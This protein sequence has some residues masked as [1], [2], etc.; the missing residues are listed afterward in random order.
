M[1]RSDAILMMDLEESRA[2]HKHGD[3]ASSHPSVSLDRSVMIATEEALE[4]LRAVQDGSN[5]QIENEAIQAANAFL[6]VAI[7]AR[8]ARE[9][10]RV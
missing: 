4:T 9:Q 8:K 3:L 7:K 2:C 1:T 6:N 10:A 5:E